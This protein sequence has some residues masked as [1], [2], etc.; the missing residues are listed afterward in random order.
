MYSIALG[1]ETA[2]ER[3]G[4]HPN[5]WDGGSDPNP[6]GAATVAPVGGD[7]VGVGSSTVIDLGRVA[8]AESFLAVSYRRTNLHFGYGRK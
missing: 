4:K 6:I 7:T 1:P 3:A 8:S 2:T 5:N